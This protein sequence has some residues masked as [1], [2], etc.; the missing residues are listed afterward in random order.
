LEDNKK[1]VWFFFDS[2]VYTCKDFDIA[3]SVVPDKVRFMRDDRAIRGGLCDSKGN[4]WICSTNGSVARYDPIEDIYKILTP[5]YPPARA[6]QG[7]LPLISEDKDGNI[8][9]ATTQN[10]LYKFDKPDNKFVHVLDFTNKSGRKDNMSILDFF[11]DSRNNFWIIGETLLSIKIQELKIV[12]YTASTQVK[13]NLMGTNIRV[14]EDSKGN[15]FILN[16]ISGVLKYS[17]LDGSFTKVNV[18]NEYFDTEYYDLLIDRRDR[19]W[20]A[21]NRGITIYSPQDGNSRMI[22]TP[23]LQFDVQAYQ[24]KSG[25]IIY[26]N[27]NRLYV[28]DEDVPVNSFTPPVYLTRLLVN[29]IEYNKIEGNSGDISTLTRLDLPYS[30]NNLNFEFAALNYLNPEENMYRY[31]MT[32]MDE[33]TITAGPGLPAEYKQMA[34]GRYKFWVTGSNN[35]GLWN[36]TGVSL[37]IRINPP[38]YRSAFAY[39]VYISAII[40]LIASYIRFRTYRL[41]SDK[42]RLKAEIEAATEELETKN[43]QLAEIDRVK[44]H[45]FTNISHEIRTPLSLILGPLENISKEEM[46]SNRM[47]QMVDLIKRNAQRLMHLVNQLLDISRLDAGKMKITLIDYDI[48]KCLKILVYEFLSIAESKH[49]EYIADIPDRVFRVWFDRDKTEKIISNLLSNAFKYTPQNGKVKCVIRID[50]AKGNNSFQVLHIKVMDSGPG[51]SEEHHGRIFDRF[52]RIEGHHEAESNGTGIGLSLVQEFVSLLHGEIKV[53]S[54]PGKGSEFSVSIPLGKDHLSPGEYVTAS[55]HDE[56]SDKHFES[57]L[58]QKFEAEKAEKTEKGKQKILI[59]EDNKDLR[60]FIKDSLCADYIV[61]EAENG[62]TGLNTAFTMMPDLIVTDIM[63]PDLDGMK[64]CSQLKND[65]ITSHIPVIMLTAKATT[66]DRI[67][68]LRSGADDYIV[69]PFN[70]T[71]LEARISNLLVLRDKLRLKYSKFRVTETGQ[72]FNE[73]VDDRFMAK[74]L[75]IINTN[76]HDYNFDVGSLHEQLGMSRTHLSRKLKIL[77]GLSPGLLLRNIRLEK[78]AEMIQAKRGNITEIANSVGIS[79]PSNFTKSFRN[80]FGVSPRDYAK[81]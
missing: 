66:N 35:D 78:A 23:K 65:E 80:Y 13:F 1:R 30:Q 42:I 28:F 57:F 25:Q 63:M 6:E 74:V 9:I 17:R 32:G 18:I 43:R 59:I 69:K 61:L 50:S 31:Y 22:R 60:N 73:S 45:F 55:F 41:T 68:G 62:R 48:I 14:C 36:P 16:G 40:S 5:H 7:F 38:W 33:D 8:W 51:I 26:I 67:E 81:H 56:T 58:K 64:L 15:L 52:Y 24:L 34:P 37:D 47:S 29:G 53:N 77:T 71:E 10:G 46:L 2:G 20:I 27:E 70:M 44:T 3:S 12:D 72:G 4:I 19:L 39:I 49:I 79:N 21:H 54:S 11:I 76:L 75:N